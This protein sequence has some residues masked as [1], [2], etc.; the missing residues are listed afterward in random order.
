MNVDLYFRKTAILLGILFFGIFSSASH[1]SHLNAALRIVLPAGKMNDAGL[2]LAARELATAYQRSTGL[3]AEIVS[4]TSPVALNS[5]PF[6]LVGS[7]NAV[8]KLS[9]SQPVRPPSNPEGFTIRRTSSHPLRIVLVGGGPRGEIYGLFYL[10]ERLLIDPNYLDVLTKVEKQP[11]FALRLVSGDDAEAAIRHGYNT[12]FSSNDHA[13]LLLF[14]AADPKMFDGWEKTRENILKKRSETS[15]QI[16]R[17][18]GYHLDALS[19]SDELVFPRALIGRPYSAKMLKPGSTR[20]CFCANKTWELYDAK[21][22]EL[23]N[24]FP[25]FDDVLIRLGENYAKDDYFGNVITDGRTWDDCPRCA[26]IPYNDRIATLIN[27]THDLVVREGGR[28]YIHRT[29]DCTDDKFHPNPQV[30]LDIVSKLNDKTNLYMSVK[31]TTTDFW[32]YNFPNPTIGIGG[33]PQI[34][35]YQ[36]QREYEG[37]GAYPNFI[38]EELSEAYRYALSKGV[39]GAWNW[40]HGGGWNGP[41]LKTDLWNEANIYVAS[42]LMWNPEQSA[43]SLAEEWAAMKFGGSNAK[44]MADLLLLSDDAVLKTV[45]FRAYAEKKKSKWMPNEN[46]VRDDVIYGNVGRLS[47]IYELVPDRVDDMIA[48][49]NESLAIVDRMIRIAATLRLKE[50]ERSQV[51]QSL[52]YERKLFTV[53]RNYAA[54]YFYYRRWKDHS[55]ANDFRRARE[56]S[57]AWRTAWSNY[58][59]LVPSFR[60]A[61]STYQDEGMESTMK[62]IASETADKK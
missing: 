23:F 50:P 45:Y 43:R 17:L 6:L 42:H 58:Q 59:A 14:D 20:I 13:Q 2:S 49:K 57:K 32:R 18:H 37:K 52:E 60:W 16:E 11:A 46:W 28:R 8:L 24:S 33:V 3:V 54:A 56:S 4:D 61:A 31:Y 1:A 48:E 40:H 39:K 7:D 62:F 25:G 38:S 51:T 26:G 53:L 15:R 19:M 12:A 34:V 44:A 21:Y 36:C 27:R 10:A 41:H 47:R 35:E 22:R 55:D 5:A 30:Y 9:S 29:W